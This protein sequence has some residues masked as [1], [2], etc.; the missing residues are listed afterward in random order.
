MRDNRDF[1]KV[2]DMVKAVNALDMEVCCTLGM[3]NEA[4]AQRLADA[5]LYAYNHPNHIPNR[6][7]WLICQRRSFNRNQ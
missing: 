3:L 1:D 5:G 7:S 2:I 6:N 4:Q